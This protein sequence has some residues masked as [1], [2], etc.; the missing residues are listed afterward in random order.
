MRNLKVLCLSKAALPILH[1]SSNSLLHY[2][3]IFCILC[4]MLC[5]HKKEP[6]VLRVNMGSLLSYVS[7]EHEQYQHWLNANLMLF[8]IKLAK[9]ELGNIKQYNLDQKS[10]LWLFSGIL[11]HQVITLI[12]YLLLHYFSIFSSLCNI[13]T[14][15]LSDE[16]T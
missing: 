13:G 3:S 9:R 16:I 15:E 6:L 8:K 12:V 4:T 5:S 10:T 2:F 11:A 1:L 14:K 7:I